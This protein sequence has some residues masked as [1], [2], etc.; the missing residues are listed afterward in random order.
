M[1]DWIICSTKATLFEPHYAG[2]IQAHGSSVRSLEPLHV[3][4][5]TPHQVQSATQ[6]FIYRNAA[7]VTKMLSD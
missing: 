1:I 6:Y 3:G 7:I 2:F 4:L 5:G